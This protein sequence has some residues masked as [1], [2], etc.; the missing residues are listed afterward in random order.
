ME[1]PPGFAQAARAV[2]RALPGRS[3]ASLQPLSGGV[4]NRV[5]R[6]TVDGAE[7]AFVLRIYARD[8][9]SCAKELALHHLVSARVPVPE[10]LYAA[11]RGD[12][13]TPPYLLMRWVRGVT[14]REL[15]SRADAPELAQA[16]SSM[17]AALARIG[18]FSFPAPGRI[19]PALAI[20]A[21]LMEG[22]DPAPRFIEQCLASPVLAR[23]MQEGLRGRVRQFAW[24]WAPRLAA[25]DKQTR[26]VHADF[27]SPNLILDRHTGRWRV[28]AVLDWEFAFSGTPL[29]D[30]AHAL[31]Y[32]RASRPRME[33]HFSHAFR[34]HGGELPEDWRALGRAADLTALCECLTRT[35]LP[36]EL[37]P[38]ILELI[39][40]TVAYRRQ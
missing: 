26:L 23:R 21:P 10:I 39:Q 14:F 24:Q 15:K 29:C 18:E 3:L 1:A 25:L 28:V 16:A 30:V 11:P 9:A 7:D 17:G 6:V 22:S 33:P 38:E 5:Y 35:A 37:V 32:E 12:G 20:G 31:R 19:G 2:A 13:E 8:P 27:G 40:A 36:E 34:G 4:C